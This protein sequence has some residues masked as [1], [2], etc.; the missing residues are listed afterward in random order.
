MTHLMVPNPFIRLDTARSAMRGI[1]QVLQRRRWADLTQQGPA[2]L[3]PLE[4]RYVPLV[5]SQTT[6]WN[7][8]CQQ[9]Q[10]AGQIGQNL[11]PLV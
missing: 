9:T 3:R 2:F 4:Q 11:T 8:P 7:V 6:A 1:G 5:V 10:K